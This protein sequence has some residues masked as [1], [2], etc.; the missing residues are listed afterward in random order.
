MEQEIFHI[1]VS[2]ADHCFTISD[3]Q[4]LCLVLKGLHQ[5]IRQE[6]ES[7][8]FASTRRRLRQFP[9]RI[10]VLTTRLRNPFPRFSLVSFFK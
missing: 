5:H 2:E 7:S 10:A 9:G 4:L 6:G 3:Y 1:F 8:L